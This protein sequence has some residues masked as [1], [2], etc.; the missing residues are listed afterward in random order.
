MLS[1]EL[2]YK[3]K[4][5]KNE[6]HNLLN[7]PIF[8]IERNRLEELKFDLMF[9]IEEKEDNRKLVDSFIVFKDKSLVDSEKEDED[10]FKVETLRELYY[11]LDTRNDLKDRI[12]ETPI[13]YSEQ[14]EE[15]KLITLKDE[16]GEEVLVFKKI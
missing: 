4:K 6:N 8:I 10:I 1:K 13:L 3:L 15:L 2:F 12:L 14:L 7:N 11:F 5:I 9:S 16:A